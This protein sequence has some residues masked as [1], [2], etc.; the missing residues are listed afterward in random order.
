MR[1]LL[2]VVLALT[3]CGVSQDDFSAMLEEARACQTG[4]SC[5]LAGG[6]QCTCD[7]PV[8]ASKAAS[9]DEA[10]DDVR[11]G[12]AQVECPGWSNPRCEAGRCVAD[13]L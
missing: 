5:A 3:A 6:G 7:S 1:V 12:G 10:A 9:I 8:N 13:P 2:L 11:C 4:E